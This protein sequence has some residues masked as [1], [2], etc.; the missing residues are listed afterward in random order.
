MQ[1]A[2]F[3]LKFPR[4]D[5][6]PYSDLPG[7]ILPQV[8]T[9]ALRGL[10][11]AASLLADIGDRFFHTT[12]LIPESKPGEPYHDDADRYL[13]GV[14]SLPD[15]MVGQHASLVGL[16]LR[17]WIQDV[18]GVFDK[19]RIY[20]WMRTEIFSTPEVASE[21]LAMSD[22]RFW[23][24]EHRRE[25]LHLLRFRWSDLDVE[26]RHRLEEKI[27]SGRPIWEGEEESDHR[28]LR[29][30]GSAQVLGWLES[31]Q[32]ALSQRALDG[33]RALQSNVPDWKDEWVASADATHDGRGDV[34][35]I[36]DDPG[37]LLGLP[38][39]DI[40]RVAAQHT[41]QEHASF[42]DREPFRGLVKKRPLRAVA[43]LS[44]EARHQR[45][46]TERWSDVLAVWPQDTSPRLQR[47]LAHRLVCLPQSTV[48]ELRDYAPLWFQRQLP[49]LAVAHYCEVLA[50]WDALAEHFYAGA[51]VDPAVS[52][53]SRGAGLRGSERVVYSRRTAECAE[54][55]ALAILVRTLIEILKAVTPTAG[56][57]AQDDFRRRLERLLGVAGD[58]SDYVVCTCTEYIRSLDELDPEWTER[59][60]VP[61]FDPMGPKAEP[62]WSGYFHPREHGRLRR[63]LFVALKPHL[64]RAFEHASEWHWDQSP[65]VSLSSLLVHMCHAGFVTT[66]EARSALRMAGD[67]GRTMAADRLGQMFKP[68]GSPFVKT[69]IAEAWPR[70]LAC[71]SERVTREFVDLAWK[72]GG[73]FADVV[74]L[75]CDVVGPIDHLVLPH[76]EGGAP[77]SEFAKSFPDKL[78]TFLDQVVP[79]NPRVAP[80]GLGIALRAIG[81]E[82][83]RLRQ[84]PAWRR[85]NGLAHH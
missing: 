78:L 56:T 45:Y 76:A 2:R 49:R 66:A 54:G 33:A 47:L 52:G 74:D 75:L 41:V 31:H 83:P 27:L 84:D 38:L 3:E 1:V 32:C 63:E 36:V 5:L 79:N 30:F 6:V 40:V 10:E 77:L 12:T 59:H 17:R 68:G 60:V 11:R 29:S 19:V 71:R 51:Q 39:A 57:T 50:L 34:V 37:S 80:H 18:R 58:G 72:A 67:E 82:A 16:E 13:L 15:R 61:W 44:Y 8:F 70:E 73:E 22:D 55:S 64:L 24:T 65:L 21:L 26:T 81:E 25:L 9:I 53:S 23:E 69:F 14:G 62:A 46:P 42:T 7:D 48:L 20:G 4:L 28:R 85:L 43:A 35:R